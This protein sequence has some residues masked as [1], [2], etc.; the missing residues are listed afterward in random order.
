MSKIILNNEFL[1]YFIKFQTKFKFKSN[2]VLQKTNGLENSGEIIWQLAICLFIAWALVF[3]CV[4]KGIK[5]SGKVLFL[6]KFFKKKRKIIS[7]FTNRLSIL[8]VCFL[9]WFF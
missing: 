3:L 8:R 4:F 9:M 2:Y 1:L 5:S 6:D 7:K